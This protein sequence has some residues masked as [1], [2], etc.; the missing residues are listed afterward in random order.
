M[1]LVG[2]QDQAPSHAYAARESP[3]CDSRAPRAGMNTW[4][5]LS[6]LGPADLDRKHWRSAETRS[7]PALCVSYSDQSDAQ[8]GSSNSIASFVFVLAVL[9]ESATRNTANRPP[10]TKS[11]CLSY[12][13]TSAKAF[14]GNLWFTILWNIPARSTRFAS[15]GPSAPPIGGQQSAREPTG[16]VGNAWLSSILCPCSPAELEPL[17]TIEAVASPTGEMLAAAEVLNR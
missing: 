4:L 11:T 7:A 17:P 15:V 3:Q 10:V 6:H 2:H 14:L 9:F 1:E 12:P 13:S 16:G 8:I 5:D